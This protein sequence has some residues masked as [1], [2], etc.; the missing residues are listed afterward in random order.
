MLAWAA[1]RHP[2]RAWLNLAGAAVL[3][4][5]WWLGGALTRLVR[6]DSEGADLGWMAAGAL[7]TFPTGILAAV[8]SS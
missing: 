5:L 4:G 1:A 2:E 6:S 3:F 7:I 8:L